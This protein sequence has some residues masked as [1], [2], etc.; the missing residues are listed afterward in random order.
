MVGNLRFFRKIP[1]NSNKRVTSIDTNEIIL[2]N[3][4]IMLEELQNFERDFG[5]DDEGHKYHLYK[6][7]VD[8]MRVSQTYPEV[9]C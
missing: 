2:S 4:K 9:I 5:S 3:Q 7:V 8:A 1:I 6:K